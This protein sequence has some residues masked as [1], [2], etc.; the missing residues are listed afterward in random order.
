MSTRFLSASLLASLLMLGACSKDQAAAPIPADQVIATVNGQKISKAQFE[1]YMQTIE[2]QAGQPIPEAQKSLVLDQY[3]GMRLAAAEAEKAGIAKQPEVA[4]QLDFARLNII[5]DA[6]LE[7]YLEDHPVADEEIRPEYDAQVAALPREYHA[8]HILVADKATAEAITKQIA[9]G[10]DFAKIAKQKS[11]DSSKDTGGD[12]GWFTLETMVEP[13]ANAVA[14]LQPGEMT[15]EPVQSQ[16]GWHVIKLEETRAS[17]APPFEN[18][19]DRVKM[20]VQ[21]K[22]LQAYLDG[23]RADAKIDINSEAVAST[24]SGIEEPAAAAHEEHDHG[25]HGDHAH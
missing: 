25:D 20:M 3:I 21:R 22:K 12:L 15:T 10:A 17:V 1:L 16:F 13:F 4:D 9:G 2:H 23:L 19:K 8:R 5:V 18:V 7:K 11:T 14:A 24:S 6:A